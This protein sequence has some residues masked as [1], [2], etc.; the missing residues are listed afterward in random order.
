VTVATQAKSASQGAETRR[1]MTAGDR[2]ETILAAALELFSASGLAGVSLDEVA[3][4]AGISKALIYEHFGSKREL[5]DAV[6]QASHNQLVGRV[7]D[8]IADAEAPEERLRLGLDAFLGFVEEHRTAWRMVHRNVTDPEVAPTLQ[9][10][11]DEARTTVAALIRGHA[12]EES[13]IEGVDLAMAS[14]MFAQQ[15]VGAGQSLANWWDDHR[16]VPRETILQAHMDFAW[17]GL[18]RIVAG[19]RWTD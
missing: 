5:H 4:R 17:V 11:Q 1:R 15:L 12:P 6:L 18:E 14:E 16:D 2:R 7:L 19:E 10:V 8:S 13:P 3:E 9:R